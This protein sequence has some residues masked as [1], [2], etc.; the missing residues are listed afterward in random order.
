MADNPTTPAAGKDA[1]NTTPETRGADQ[2]TAQVQTAE[3]ERAAAILSLY[4]RHGM[5]DAAP[6]AIAKG[7]TLDQARAAVLDVLASRTAPSAPR[8]EPTLTGRLDE[9]ETLRR[10]MEEA[11][12]S[13]FTGKPVTELGRTFEGFDLVDLAAERLG[14]RRVPGSF[15]ARE[16]LL[17]RAFHS[18]SD[19]P[20]L[21]ENA[22]NKGLQARYAMQDPTYRKIAKKRP[23]YADFR[24]HTT[25]R[26]GDFPQLQAVDQEA[27]E[28]KAGTF[29]EARERTSVTPYGVRVNLSRQMLV[30]DGL[31]GIQQVLN[32]R[33][34]AVA[35]FE[36]ATFYAMAF[37]GASNNGPTLLETTRQVFN[38]TDGT[39]AGTN[40][41]VTVASITVGRSA[42]LKRKS[43][44]GA[45]LEL[46]PAVLLVGPDKLTEAQQLIAPIQA[47]QA[48]N[49]NPFTGTME[50]VCTAKITGLSWYL[51][52]SPDIAPVFEYG[53]LDGYEAPRFRIEDLFGIQGTSLTLEHDFG[54]GA[55]DWRGGFRNIGA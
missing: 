47:Q 48:S 35:R 20:I 15:G 1:A 7:L 36:D 21:F 33:G 19:F 25:I 17:K 2:V 3:R 22:L 9:T 24:P 27:G 4:Q 28:I 40:A 30:N 53:Y 50:V 45:D 6:D 14:V 39:L 46:F 31:G 23:N 44:D 54:C 10:G 55:I 37:G 12:T 8:H 52:A 5:A 11:L 34:M 16:E 29:S 42:M 49:V 43:R 38:T 32:D 26:V 13:A 41:A 18:T 51:F